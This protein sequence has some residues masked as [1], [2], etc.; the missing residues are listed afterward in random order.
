LTARAFGASGVIIADTRDEKIQSTVKNVVDD[1]GGHF[2]FEMGNPWRE[3]V[4]AWR[5]TGGT[6][7]HLTAY[8]ENIESSD[9]M[10][11]IVDAGQS[12]MVLIGSK[13]VP[14]DFYREGIS[15]FNVAVGNQ[16]HS[17][18]AALAIFL[19]RLLGGESLR[20]SFPG[21]KLSIS[22]SRRGKRILTR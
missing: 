20:L 14:G 3:A 6:V 1:W 4:K 11:R 8:G 7:V 18:V 17:E 5:A 10:R 21:A 2:Q 22:P 12:V 19:Y 15:D 13:K 9:V 16:P